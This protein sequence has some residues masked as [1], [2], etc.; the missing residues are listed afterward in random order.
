MIYR[1]AW[2][3]LIGI[4]ETFWGSQTNGFQYYGTGDTPVHMYIY[5][6]GIWHVCQWTLN[7]QCDKENLVQLLFG[8]ET[9]ENQNSEC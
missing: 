3:S 1:Y 4:D 9:K 7:E 8:C 2:P 5:L 6:C